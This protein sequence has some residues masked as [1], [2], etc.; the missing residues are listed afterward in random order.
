LRLHFP[1]A[2][3]I[4]L[5]QMRKSSAEG[6]QLGQPLGKRLWSLETEDLPAARLGVEPIGEECRR[7]VRLEEERQGATVGREIIRKT[8]RVFRGLGLHASKRTLGLCFYCT[9]RFAIHVEQV[10]RKPESR[11][12]RKLAD[13]D[14]ATCCE[15]KVVPVLH[16]PTR[17]D[18]LRINLSAGFL[19]GC[20]GH[21]CQLFQSAK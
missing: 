6:I 12:H 9:E 14:A 19:F 5:R 15:V 2:G 10:I 4:Q 17:R 8:S 18:Q 3:L 16:K 11:L 1:E 13:G 20:L 7:S 21:G